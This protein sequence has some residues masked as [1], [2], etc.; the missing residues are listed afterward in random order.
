[1]ERGVAAEL[2]RDG[3]RRL[4]EE[5]YELFVGDANERAITTHLAAN[6][7]DDGRIPEGLDVDHE[8]DRMGIRYQKIL[9]HWVDG[10]MELD[11]EGN[12]VEHKRYPDILVH[13]R[14]DNDNNVI[15][16]EVKVG[17]RNDVNDKSKI[18]ALTSHPF[19]YQFG[20]L[21]YLVE[22][23]HE[24]GP[25]WITRWAWNP[26]HGNP[27]IN[28]ETAFTDEESAELTRRSR[29]AAELSRASRRPTRAVRL[30]E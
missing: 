13:G 27:E 18:W 20:I 24:D 29:R 26:E 17:K 1:M 8:Y 28:Y 3:L 16:V 19:D 12:P 25:V 9:Q 30:E 7:R 4:I 11:S 21:L 14:G 22:E 10:E 23:A 15:A 2:L 6:L 5:N